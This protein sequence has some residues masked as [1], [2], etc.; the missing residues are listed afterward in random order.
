MVIEPGLTGSRCI[1]PLVSIFKEHALRK[2]VCFA[3]SRST[4]KKVEQYGGRIFHSQNTGR[5]YENKNNVIAHSLSSTKT[6]IVRANY[7]SIVYLTDILVT[8]RKPPHF[9]WRFAILQQGNSLTLTL[10]SNRSSHFFIFLRL[11]PFF[12]SS[13]TTVFFTPAQLCVNAR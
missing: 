13:G 4:R 10:L 9:H 5:K 2:E 1:N 8:D 6:R 7:E 3:N 12:L 11:D